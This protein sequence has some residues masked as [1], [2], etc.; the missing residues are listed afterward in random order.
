MASISPDQ[1]LVNQFVEACS[2]A[3]LLEMEKII[4]VYLTVHNEVNNR[5]HHHSHH[6]HN[7]NGKQFILKLINSSGE[8]NVKPLYAACE[9]GHLRIVEKL[10]ELGANV[11]GESFGYRTAIFISAK[12]G[13]ERI[14]RLLL[15]NG[16]KQTHKCLYSNEIV[17]VS[18]F[19]GVQRKR[20]YYSPEEVAI[21][22]GFNHIAELIRNFDYS[23]FCI[24]QKQFKHFRNG[25]QKH[26]NNYFN[27]IDIHH[28]TFKL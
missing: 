4:E 22:E 24:K 7:N 21:H 11:N 23:L 25:L 28:E 15:E 26:L 10:L 2:E 18:M 13:H 9:R 5:Q 16:A 14:V 1:L 3:N 20:I 8:G 27:F 12:Q 17:L 19:S 6:H